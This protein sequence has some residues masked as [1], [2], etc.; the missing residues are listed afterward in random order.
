MTGPLSAI[1]TDFPLREGQDPCFD[2]CVVTTSTGLIAPNTALVNA[3][4][5]VPGLYLF[6]V[7]VALEGAP[8]LP[9][10]TQFSK[11][12]NPAASIELLSLLAVSDVTNCVDRDSVTCRLGAGG[13]IQL[14]ILGSGIPAGT[15]I[16]SAMQYKLISR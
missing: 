7:T 9:L 4:I 13:V 1:F 6:R 10:V 14:R 15:I 11:Q 16:R 8:L 2:N 3:T 5:G 12:H